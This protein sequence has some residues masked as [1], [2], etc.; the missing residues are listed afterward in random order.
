MGHDGL[1][2]DESEYDGN[3]V[4]QLERSPIERIAVGIRSY[5]GKTFADLRTYWQ[6]NDCSWKP[7]PKGITMRLSLLRDFRAL[8]DRA[9]E[10]AGPEADTE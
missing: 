5:K 4:G 3:L 1:V 10:A 6:A 8:I 9:I 7:S 2:I